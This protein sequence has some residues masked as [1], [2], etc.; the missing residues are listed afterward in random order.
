MTLAWAVCT[1]ACVLI[2]YF[3]GGIPWAVVLGRAFFK[4][5]VRA[6]GSGNSGTTN[7]LRAFGWWTAV[8]VFL[9][10]ML[11]GFL[12]VFLAGLL[13]AQ[14]S[15]ASPT[16][17]QTSQIL[18]GIASVLGH[19]FSPYMHFT[20]GKGVATMS[21]VILGLSPWIFVAEVVIFISISLLTRY[22]SVASITIAVCYPI[23]VFVFY[24]S[25]TPM[26][27]F[28]LL[29]AITIILMHRSNLARLRAGTENK[30]ELKSNGQKKP[31]RQEGE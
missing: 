12:P 24:H 8:A 6:Q 31:S 15:N 22:V 23:M 16:L 4:T 25:S 27:V 20:G 13:T 5:D 26:L 21:G 19:M 3:L 30:L 10:D 14:F 28:S 9:L 2:G 11:K 17:I 18:A 29:M 7:A 1:V